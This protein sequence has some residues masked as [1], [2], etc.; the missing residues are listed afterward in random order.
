[1]KTLTVKNGM[2]RMQAEDSVATRLTRVVVL[3]VGYWFAGGA[4]SAYGIHLSPARVRRLRD[5]LT[6]WLNE[7]EPEKKGKV[8]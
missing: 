2:S 4:G 1:M 7:N 8:T 6:Q 5:W 3:N